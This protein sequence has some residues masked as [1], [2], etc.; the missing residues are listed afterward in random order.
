MLGRFGSGSIDFGFEEEEGCRETIVLEQASSVGRVVWLCQI[1][2]ENKE[3]ES[4]LIE[5]SWRV[6]VDVCDGSATRV[7]CPLEYGPKG[8]KP[9]KGVEGSGDDLLATDTT[10]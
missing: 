1:G 2:R 9:Q 6:W 4:W 3:R 7:C 8:N 10:K 5:A